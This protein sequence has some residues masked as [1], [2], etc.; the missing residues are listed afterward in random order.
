MMKSG[1]LQKTCP[2]CGTTLEDFRR[3]GLLGCAE[4]YQIFREEVFAA[5]RHVQGK[6][7]HEGKIPAAG[8]AN[9][10]DLVIE[11]DRLYESL[12]QAFRDGRY[13]DADKM[14]RRLEEIA[15]VLHPKEDLT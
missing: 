5:A 11:Q 9:K 13:S 1:N 14:Q 7:H 8:A 6:I 10:Y 4:C 3:T 12:A 15:R 2:N